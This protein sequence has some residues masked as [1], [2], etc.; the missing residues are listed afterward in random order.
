MVAL[1]FFVVGCGSRSGEALQPTA[2]TDAPSTG[3]TGVSVPEPAAPKLVAAKAVVSAYVEALVS[4]DGVKACGLMAPELRS[5][6]QRFPY[7]AYGQTGH[8][9]CAKALRGVD[10]SRTGA[11]LLGF[12]ASRAEGP[13]LGIKTRLRLPTSVG[14]DSG[15]VEFWV[16]ASKEGAV[17]ARDGGLV[18]L[19]NDG[20]YEVAMQA[21]PTLP[22]QAA[23]YWPA[24]QATSGCSGAVKTQAVPKNDVLT[25]SGGKT[26]ETPWL[27]IR[28]VSFYDGAKPCVEI[29]LGAPLHP[30]T[31]IEVSRGRG[32][33]T[34]GIAFDLVVGAAKR[35]YSADGLEFN[36]PHPA[37]WDE[38]GSTLVFYPD[39]V[40]PFDEIKNFD[41][42]LTST[43]LWEPYVPA[44]EAVGDAYPY[45]EAPC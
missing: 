44:Q 27:D 38:V 35:D 34:G 24:P 5:W 13:F 16:T 31:R 21:A 42:C 23:A 2:A 22:T 12:G 17:I 4:N 26:A 15:S 36:A 10:K 20:Q 8:E 40:V 14:G 45:H 3:V 33:G 29:E 11:Q 30:D 39:N 43:A 7:A 32:L 6:W 25:M 41:I 19:M 1:V 37:G 28:R 18:G 9:P